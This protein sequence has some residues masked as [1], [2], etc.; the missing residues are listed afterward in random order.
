MQKVNARLFNWATE[1]G[2]IDQALMTA[3]LPVVT[4]HV[5]LMPDAHVGMGPRSG[6]SSRLPTP[7]SPQPLEWTSAAG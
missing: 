1:A 5:A 4:G 2:T 7:S 6:Q 3:R